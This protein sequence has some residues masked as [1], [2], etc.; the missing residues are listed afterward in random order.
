M[1]T[2]MPG[3]SPNRSANALHLGRLY[4]KKDPGRARQGEK[5]DYRTR[6]RIALTSDIRH[7]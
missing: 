4:E 1:A 3:I 7:G 6:T 5:R 2:G